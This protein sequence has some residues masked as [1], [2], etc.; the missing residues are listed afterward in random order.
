MTKLHFRKESL[1]YVIILIITA[2]IFYF[3]LP[4]L[5]IFP[6]LILIFVVYFFRDPERVISFDDDSILSPAD[7]T[8]MDIVEIDDDTELND[9][10]ISIADIN[11]LYN[12]PVRYRGKIYS[13]NHLFINIA[14]NQNKIIYTEEE[15]GLLKKGNLK[16]LMHRLRDLCGDKL[17]HTAL[18]NFNKVLLFLYSS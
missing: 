11:E 16:K 18:W 5:A 13:Y 8:V 7:G 6:V 2:I 17:Y 3:V 4:V 1:P 12:A 10:S 15:F 14:L 9:I